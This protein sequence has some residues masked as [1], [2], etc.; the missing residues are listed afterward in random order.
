MGNEVE[1]PATSR[2]IS[3]A[4]RELKGKWALIQQRF[5]DLTGNDLILTCTHRT[6]AEQQRLYAQ[7]RTTKGNI[8]TWVDGIK[9]KSNHN[10]YP[11]KAIDVA[12]L[13]GGKV[14]WA[15]EAYQALG[16]ICKD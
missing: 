2:D 9:K 1:R 8:V 11:S 12:V 5:H 4:D 3:D 6:V 7:G 13:S 14:N 10:S 16:I 15:P